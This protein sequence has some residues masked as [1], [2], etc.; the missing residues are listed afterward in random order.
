M[1]EGPRVFDRESVEHLA[2]NLDNAGVDID[3]AATGRPETVDAGALSGEVMALMAELAGAAGDLAARM[4]CVA[5]SML[6]VAINNGDVEDEGMHTLWYAMGGPDRPLGPLGSGADPFMP[7][8][9][10]LPKSTG[11][12]AHRADRHDD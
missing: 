3:Q 9:E 2:H 11:G 7:Y 10:S 6:L 5:D 8:T 4:R 1:R 12:G